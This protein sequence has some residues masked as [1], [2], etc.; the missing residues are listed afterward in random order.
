[1]CQ[2]GTERAPGARPP[3][4]VT[5]DARSR[6]KNFSSCRCLSVIN[7]RFLLFSHPPVEIILLMHSYT[8]EHARV[9]RPAILSAIPQIYPRLSGI[10]PH[11]IIAIRN[12]VHFSA[13]LWHP[14]TMGDIGRLQ[15]QKSWPRFVR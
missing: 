2:V 9:L 7:C 10:E 14:V 15:L 11:M 8:N 5:V 1:M 12:Q 4:R 13:E 3:D 6:E